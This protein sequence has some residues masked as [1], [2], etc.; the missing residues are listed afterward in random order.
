VV[1]L[2][3]LATSE[4]NTDGN[5]VPVYKTYELELIA[6]HTPIPM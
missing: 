1:G 2:F 3:E 6:N 4:V 5:Y